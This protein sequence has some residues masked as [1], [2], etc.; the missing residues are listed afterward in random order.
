[1]SA[2]FGGGPADVAAEPV[3]P[4]GRSELV[5]FT[6]LAAVS[7]LLAMGAGIGLV[8]LRRTKRSEAGSHDSPSSYGLPGSPGGAHAAYFGPP[9]SDSGYGAAQ[10]YSTGS[11]Y[12]G[13][14]GYGG[15]PGYG[16]GWPDE[17]R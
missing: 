9:G 1:V 14:P 17:Q 6:V 5:L 7:L 10:G 16:T 15:S 12:G 3:A 2:D 4:R 13:P 8:M 11:G